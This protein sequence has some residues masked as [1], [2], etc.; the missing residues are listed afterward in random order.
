MRFLD[1]GVWSS[2]CERSRGSFRAST[3]EL[4]TRSYSGCTVQRVKVYTG[5]AERMEEADD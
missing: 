4:T 2:T 5:M 3:R 1:I